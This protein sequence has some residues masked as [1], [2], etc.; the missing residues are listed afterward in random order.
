MTLSA[1]RLRF[2]WMQGIL[3]DT[4][5][6]HAARNILVRCALVSTLGGEDTFSVRQQTVADAM[7]TNRLT[8]ARALQRAR[9]LGWLDLV[10]ERQRGRGW[11][12]GDTHRLTFPPEIGDPGV[13]YSSCSPQE[14]VT[15]ESEIGD[16]RVTYSGEIGDSRVQEYVTLQSRNNGSTSQNSTPKG[17]D[18]GYREEQGFKTQGVA[19]EKNNH[20]II[21]DT[22]LRITLRAVEANVVHGIST[23]TWHL[24]SN[25]TIAQ[26][27]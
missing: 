9:E 6:P 14:Y 1:E 25:A 21:D 19:L 18:K 7:G 15:P 8:V 16:S 17:I 11:H 13:T 4:R 10:E 2:L 20:E 12:K 5:L 3:E 24:A 27:Q 26:A 23:G 22:G